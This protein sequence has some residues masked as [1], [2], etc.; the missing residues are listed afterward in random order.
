MTAAVHPA[1]V[2]GAMR[3]G[4]FLLHR[5]RIH[6]GPER[7]GVGS[8]GRIGGLDPAHHAGAGKPVHERDAVGGQLALDD[9]RGIRF[10]EAEL[11][12]RMQL[13]SDPDDGRQHLFNEVPQCR[14][15]L[16]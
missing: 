7:D 2:A 13:A 1:V 16:R 15:A 9:R 10:L 4:V 11:R 8:D 12:I 6:V 14:T 3:E 5:K